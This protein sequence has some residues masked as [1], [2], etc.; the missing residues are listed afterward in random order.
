MNKSLINNGGLF[1]YSYE[2][3]IVSTHLLLSYPIPQTEHAPSLQEGMPTGKGTLFFS[4]HNGFGL[5]SLV[6][7]SRKMKYS[8][9]NNTQKLFIKRSTGLF[10]I[11]T[12]RI[13][14]NE[15][16][17]RK[18]L[19]LRIVE[20][21]DI[22]I[23]VVLQ[24]LAIDRQ[25]T[26]IITEDIS[27][28]THFLAIVSRYGTYPCTDTRLRENGKSNLSVS[29]SNRNGRYVDL[30]IQ[31]DSL[32]LTEKQCADLFYPDVKNLPY[33]LCRQIIRDTGEASNMRGCGIVARPSDK[34][35][36]IIVTL[37]IYNNKK[38]IRKH[39]EF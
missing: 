38:R 36:D 8:V 11:G 30:H 7:L 24:E 18:R 4:G 26:L 16:I 15:N 35:T 19:T 29:L 21:N 33:L 23:V 25:N 3:H 14:T 17:T 27:N 20:S 28:I 22:G 9:N 13:Q 1:Y 2:V 34:G 37:A 12:D 31:M 39:E 5:R 6:A 32:S 10:C